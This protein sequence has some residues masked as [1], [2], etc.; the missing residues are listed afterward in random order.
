MFNSNCLKHIEG[1][2]PDWDISTLIYSW[3]TPFWSETLDIT[4]DPDQFRNVRENE[5]SRLCFLLTSWPSAS[6][7]PHDPLLPAD[8]MTLCSLLTSWPS[9]SCW[10]HDPLL[11]ADLMTLCQSQ[12]QWK[13][14]KWLMSVLPL[15]RAGMSE[16]K[17]LAYNA[18]IQVFARKGGQTDGKRLTGELATHTKIIIT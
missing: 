6:C 14:I 17:K 13:W 4:F 18:L 11:P 8:L 2:Q 1:F 7:W 5:A 16:F 12:G 3:D 9:A 15:S 10:P